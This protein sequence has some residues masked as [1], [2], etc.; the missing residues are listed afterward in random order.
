MEVYFDKQTRPVGEEIK[1]KR[2]PKV[3]YEGGYKQHNQE[4]KYHLNYYHKHKSLIHK[5]KISLYQNLK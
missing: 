3:K 2:G 4:Q 1:L 5:Y